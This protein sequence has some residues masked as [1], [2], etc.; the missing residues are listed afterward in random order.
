MT[1]K[2]LFSCTFLILIVVFFSC[3]GKNSSSSSL[4]PTPSPSTPQNNSG[5]GK[6]G[7]LARFTVIGDHLYAVN[8]REIKAFDI[9]NPAE[10]KE[11][12]GQSID[13]GIETV[14][15][16]YPYLFI[17]GQKGLYIYDVSSD[18]KSPSFVSQ[19]GHARACDPVVIEN[20]YA[21]ITL[22]SS[23]MCPGSV[24]E[25]KVVDVSNI[26]QPKLIKNYPL[27]APVGLAS[28]EGKLYICDGDN[29]KLFNSSDVQN[30]QLKTSVER[31]GCMDM[32]FDRS[33]VIVTSSQGITQYDVSNDIFELLSHLGF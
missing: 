4:S 24:N 26:R 28:N 25:L 11:V 22:R 16:S 3:K 19:F 10:T 31:I 8:N 21:F 17:G 32:I 33:A 2:W 9:S 7:S 27:S 30:V 15:G 20:D 13:F 6:V 1:R 14:S 5:V 18:P 23:N 29:L 12:S